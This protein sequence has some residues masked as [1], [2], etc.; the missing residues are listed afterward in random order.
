[1]YPSKEEIGALFIYCPDSGSLFWRKPI[2]NGAQPMLAGY[3]KKDG[4]RYIS[5]RNKKYLAHRLIWILFNGANPDECIDHKNRDKADNRIENLRLAT[6]EQNASNSKTYK[7]NT[8]GLKGVSFCKRDKRFIA[9]ITKGGKAKRIGGFSTAQEASDAY[10][11]ASLQINKEF[12]P[13]N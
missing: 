13:F 8:T 6:R 1:M 2:A 10:K 11:K 3:V 9:Y 7:T 12:S 4:Y 5:I